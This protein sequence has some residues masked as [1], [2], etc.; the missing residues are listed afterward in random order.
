MHVHLKLLKKLNKTNSKIYTV[1]FDKRKYYNDFDKNKLYNKLVG[2]LAEHLKIN[3][4]LTVRIDRSKAN[5]RDMEIFNKY[6]EKK[7][8]LKNELKLKIFH[9][10]SHEWN[11]LQIIDIIAWSYFQKYENQKSEF[12]DIIKLETKIIE[13]N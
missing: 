11:G 8:S 9:S 6:F 5:T 7:L 13:A 4:N 2:I 10:Y 1:I 12:I 3:S